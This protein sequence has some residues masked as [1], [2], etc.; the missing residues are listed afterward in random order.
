MAALSSLDGLAAG[1]A[2]QAAAARGGGPAEQPQFVPGPDH[3]LEELRVME[4]D[5]RTFARGERSRRPRRRA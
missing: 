4:V 2:W 3:S 1:A 5:V